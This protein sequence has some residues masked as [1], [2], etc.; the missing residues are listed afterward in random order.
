MRDI[1]AALPRDHL[2]DLAVD[3][4]HVG[5]WGPDAAKASAYNN[6]TVHIYDFAVYGAA[7]TLAGLFLHEFG[8]A[9]YASLKPEEVNVLAECHDVIS[10]HRGFMG[11][12][13]LLDAQSRVV[14]QEFIPEEF[15][16]ETYLL[17]TACGGALREFIGRQEDEAAEAWWRAYSVFAH[18]FH[19]I[20]YL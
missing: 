6:G 7:R 15:V 9:F 13:Y 19:G 4:L 20:G 16:A 1:A 10:R 5:G 14:Y 11:V 18:G 17:Y 3:C 8:H 2:V 12:E